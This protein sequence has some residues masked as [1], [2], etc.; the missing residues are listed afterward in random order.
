GEDELELADLVAAVG[1]RADVVALDPELRALRDGR[2]EVERLDGR[3]ELA[4][5][6]PRDAGGQLGETAEE[7]RG[8]G[9]RRSSGA[10][11]LRPGRITAWIVGLDRAHER[12][13]AMRS[14][15]A[16]ASAM[17]VICGGTPTDVGNADAS[18]I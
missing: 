3:G 11:T 2:A 15:V 5:R 18:A 8:V 4:D 6:Q 13:S 10:A 7:G 1:M 9:G 16:A 12:V 14:A 17:V